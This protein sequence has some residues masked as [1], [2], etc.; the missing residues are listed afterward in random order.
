MGGDSTTAPGIPPPVD[1]TA[2]MMGASSNN[3]ITALGQQGVMTL[4]IMENAMV[5]SQVAASNLELGLSRLDE[6]LEEAKLNFRGEQLAE[7]NHHDE[8]MAEIEQ[9]GN[10]T[11]TVDTT[12]FLE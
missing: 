9:E 3:M 6:R 12:D 5:Q 7:R 4:G 1:Y 8:R 2:A 11:E 10:N